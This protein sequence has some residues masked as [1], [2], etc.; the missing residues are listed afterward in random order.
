MSIKLQIQFYQEHEKKDG[1]ISHFSSLSYKQTAPHP[2]G[3]A[4]F[5]KRAFVCTEYGVWLNALAMKNIAVQIDGINICM[6]IK[7]NPQFLTQQVNWKPASAHITSAGLCVSLYVCT[8]ARACLY[9]CT[10]PLMQIIHPSRSVSLACNG[11]CC[12]LFQAWPRRKCHLKL[13]PLEAT[14][15][16]SA[17]YIMP[18]FPSMPITYKVLYIKDSN[19]QGCRI[20]VFCFSIAVQGQNRHDF[21]HVVWSC[22]LFKMFIAFTE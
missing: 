1:G 22:F 14:L 20:Q 3:H 13:P 9:V 12:P 11:S 17:I 10:C 19:Q 16:N 2:I 6:L 18:S 8:H 5:F 7:L 15:S 4:F 21:R